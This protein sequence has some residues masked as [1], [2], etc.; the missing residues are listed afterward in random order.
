MHIL[1]TGGTGFIGSRLVPVLRDAGHN[2]SVLSRSPKV[3]GEAGLTYLTDLASL[4]NAVDA[5]INLAGASLAGK[6]WNAEYKQE[7]V[8]SR[9]KITRQL[10][11]ALRQ[12]GDVPGV[13]INASAI[14][15]YGPRDDERLDESAEKGQGFSADLCADWEQAA[16]DA[17]DEQTRVCSLRL[18]V[19]LGPD[20]GAYAQMA[21]PFRMGVGNWVGSGAQWLSW[22]H[23]EDAVAAIKFLLEQSSATGVFNVT[24]PEP[25]TS[26]DFCTAMKK[27]HRTLITLP[28]PGPVMRVMVGEM[29]DELLLTGQ[30][31][32]PTGLQTAGF[33]FQ[34]GH[35][36]AALADIESSQA[37]R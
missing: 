19:V 21:Q 4:E 29:A 14:G 13:W 35:I 30:R 33:V 17:A 37:L 26:R 11:E 22:I 25:V 5:V 10:G 27:V 34:F 7:I 20:G 28:M 18:G 15:F 12:R 9:L 16:L 31:V 23:R 2:V 6:R 24:A 32:I 8:G 36:D 1:V 3:S